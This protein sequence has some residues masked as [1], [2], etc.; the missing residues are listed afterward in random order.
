MLI[1]TANLNDLLTLPA[2]RQKRALLPI[3]NINRLFVEIIII[4]A[5]EITRLL[6]DIL[7]TIVGRLGLTRSWTLTILPRIYLLLSLHI[8]LSGLLIRCGTAL[9]SLCCTY[10]SSFLEATTSC[11]ALRSHRVNIRRNHFL[12]L[13]RSSLRRQV[14]T[15]SFSQKLL[16]LVNLSLSKSAK[17]AFNI[18]T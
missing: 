7:F 8:I 1:Q 5:A 18:I 10:T 12:S 2:R 17:S 6:I 3:V 13:L 16:D 14:S 15:I 11:A 9:P 4:L